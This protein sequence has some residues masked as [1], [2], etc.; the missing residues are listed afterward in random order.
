MAV[1]GMHAVTVAVVPPATA[2]RHGG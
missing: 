2:R 1:A